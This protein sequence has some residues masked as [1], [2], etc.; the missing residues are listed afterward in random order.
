MDEGSGAVDVL[1]AERVYV[2]QKTLTR[3][4]LYSLVLRYLGH[5]RL[6]RRKGT[7]PAAIEIFMFELP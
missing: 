1:L 6:D 5:S 4:W 7:T 2:S 3:I